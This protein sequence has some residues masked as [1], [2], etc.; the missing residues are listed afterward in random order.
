MPF[1]PDAVNSVAVS[2][3]VLKDPQVYHLAAQQ[4]KAQLRLGLSHL[5]TPAGAINVDA[6]VDASGTTRERGR[7]AAWH[8]GT[9]CVLLTTCGPSGPC[10]VVGTSKW[11]W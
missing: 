1:S 2:G 6:S 10:T 8:V 5:H 4:V 9:L 7:G 3:T 11:V